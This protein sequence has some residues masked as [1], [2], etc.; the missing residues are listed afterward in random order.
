MTAGQVFQQKI[1]DEATFSNEKEGDEELGSMC[2][3]H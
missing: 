2:Y 3:S 1:E